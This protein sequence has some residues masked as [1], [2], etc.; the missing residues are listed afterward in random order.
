MYIIYIYVRV[1][2]CMYA[3]VREYACVYVYSN[4]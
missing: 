3:S 4:I 1:F 2:M